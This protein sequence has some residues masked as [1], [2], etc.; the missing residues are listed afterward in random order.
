MTD[1]HRR[2]GLEEV[3]VLRLTVCGHN[4]WGVPESSIAAITVEF[5]LCTVGLWRSG[6]LLEP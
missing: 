3:E 4:N 5:L 2:K 1:K 6:L